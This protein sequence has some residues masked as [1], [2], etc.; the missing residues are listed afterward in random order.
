MKRLLAGKKMRFAAIALLFGGLLTNVKAQETEVLSLNLDQ[1]VEF[2]LSE[3]PTVKVANKEIE[4][5]KYAKKGAYA[6]LF[7]QVDFGADYSR[8]LKKQVMYMDG[9]FDM[10]SMMA[11]V[12]NGID[13]TF[14]SSVPGYTPGTLNQE[15]VLIP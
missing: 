13:N 11:P 1:A 7:P 4:K 12:F 15:I 5:K 9:A 3:S 8:T 2:A 14:A 6:A 10:T